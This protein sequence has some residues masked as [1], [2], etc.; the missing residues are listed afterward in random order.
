MGKVK[1]VTPTRTP[2]A[3]VE[4]SLLDAAEALL[5]RD[6]PEALTVRGIAAEAGVAPMGVYNRFGSKDGVLDALFIRGFDE[7]EAALRAV[8]EPD[9][10]RALIAAGVA[11]RR[12]AQDHPQM[13]GLM[14]ENRSATFVPSEAA[15]ER[16][17]ATFQH[18]VRHVEAAMRARV[19]RKGD[20]I[21][22]AQRLWS[23]CHGVVSLEL[24]GMG[25]VDD[26][27]AHH[28]R[29]LE[30]LLAGLK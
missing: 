30:T 11:Y 9:P 6:G 17:A 28:R 25:F 21:E 23:A 2:S 19:I 20:P 14:F 27:D 15:H 13:Y 16:A 22:V 3:A 24:R 4:S 1:R 10:K 26:V 12:F 29:L 18:L 7:F 8:D 5:E